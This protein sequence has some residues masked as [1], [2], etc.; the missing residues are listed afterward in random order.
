MAASPSRL[1]ILTEKEPR[2]DAAPDK[3]SVAREPASLPAGGNHSVQGKRSL[4][5]PNKVGPA[6][7]RAGVARE[8][9]DRGGSAPDVLCVFEIKLGEV[10]NGIGAR[11]LDGS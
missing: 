2:R 5:V 10:G 9:S 11:P 8:Q 3:S 4:P 7:L 6:G 1:K